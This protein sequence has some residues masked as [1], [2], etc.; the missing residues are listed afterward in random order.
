MTQHSLGWN[1]LQALACYFSSGFDLPDVD[2][3]P[4]V[5]MTL[6]ERTTSKRISCA[7]GKELPAIN[8]L[9]EASLVAP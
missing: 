6:P 9:S 7:P 2:L 4:R 8:N 3:Y 1:G 5:P